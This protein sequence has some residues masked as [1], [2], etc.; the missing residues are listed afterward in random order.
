MLLYATIRRAVKHQKEK[1][2]RIMMKRKRKRK[3]KR[4]KVR[5]EKKKIYQFCRAKLEVFT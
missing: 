4:G 2:M 5:E 1:H 3:R